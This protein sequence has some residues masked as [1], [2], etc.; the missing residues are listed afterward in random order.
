MAD[1]QPNNPIDMGPFVGAGG[2]MPDNPDPLK[3][4]SNSQPPAPPR[5]QKA[6][7]STKAKESANAFL[8]VDPGAVPSVPESTDVEAFKRGEIGPGIKPENRWEKYWSQLGL[9]T[10]D[11][12]PTS[13]AI[14]FYSDTQNELLQF[15]NGKTKLSPEEL[16]KQFPESKFNEPQ[17]PEVARIINDRNVRR[18]QL[19]TWT[20]KG[21]DTG[22]LFD[23]AATAPIGA[24]PYNIVA[25]LAIGE[26]LGAL[27]VA[28]RLRGVLPSRF[29]ALAEPS[30][31][32]G[33]NFAAN[34]AGEAPAYLQRSR[35]G[36]ANPPIGEIL[37]GSAEGAVLGTGIH[38][39]IAGALS[40]ADA[41]VKGQSRALVENTAETVAKQIDQNQK[42][43][44]GPATTLEAAREL[45]IPARG[46][47]D[48]YEYRALNHPGEALYHVPVH[49]D[50]G[51]I[52]ASPEM[53]GGVSGSD[54]RVVAVNQAGVPERGV[55]GK[56]ITVRPSPETTFIDAEASFKDSLGEGVTVEEG[57]D[58]IK[59]I[60]G[61]A[62][63]RRY[64]AAFKELLQGDASVGE[65]WSRFLELPYERITPENKIPMQDLK[66]LLDGM[67]YD[68]MSFRGSAA[69]VPTDNRAIFFKPEQ[70]DIVKNVSGDVADAA[71]AGDVPEF[72]AA[73]RDELSKLAEAPE[74]QKGYDPELIAKIK[75]APQ[76]VKEFETKPAEVPAEL[77]EQE[78]NARAWLEAEGAEHP[79]VIK[80][81]K[82]IDGEYKQ[83]QSLKKAVQNLSECM[84]TRVI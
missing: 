36:R 65:V 76:K 27:G 44:V 13:N 52:S 49:P 16:N 31:I 4:E 19:K 62:R 24:D 7:E 20:N 67:G 56:T 77:V 63:F 30:T 46:I 73:A 48:T 8:G 69:G 22:T 55:D 29:G 79:E 70:L 66:T 6:K 59:G 42:V 12:A 34:L 15:Q 45:G 2:V 80:E 32:Y 38:Y 11:A 83:V 53:G 82:A 60:L 84:G 21:P 57:L 3:F 72:D 23:F 61:D 40:R 50:T 14:K 47:P 68:A 26:G 37:K 25:A 81:M 33:S 5:K 75:E 18:E 1:N 74:N 64:S 51:A 43:H 39:L 35:E 58:K 41:S 71:R 28:N 10:E 9:N 78:A 54:N 17:Y